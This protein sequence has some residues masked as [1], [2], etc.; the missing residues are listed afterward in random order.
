MLR[1]L[2]VVLIVFGIILIV[3][4]IALTVWNIIQIN[5]LVTTANVANMIY[6]PNPRYWVLMGTL[7]ALACGLTLGAGLGLPKR[8]FKQR[9]VAKAAAT[10]TADHHSPDMDPGD[11]IS[12]TT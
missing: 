8:S 12:E 9:L 5:H 6:N 11:P 7:G 4:V 1:F 10:A 2:K 3:G